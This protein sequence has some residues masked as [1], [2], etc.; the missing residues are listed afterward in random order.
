MRALED[1]Y[2]PDD[3]RPLTAFAGI[4]AAYGATV[5]GLSLLVRATGR[6]LPERM[7][8]G[9][10]A[11]TAVATYR[12]ARIVAKSPVTSPL[13]A[14]FTRFR[15]VCGE[16]ELEEEVRGTGWRKAMGE[17][18]SCPFCLGQ[19]VVTG[20]GFGWVFAP[21]ATRMVTS[22]L[23]A[24]AVADTLHYGHAALERTKG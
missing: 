1:V 23:S 24:A 6:R 3:E 5:G 16:A 13:R 19:W 22:M 4:M 17:L 7:P 18:V 9:D 20:F 21:R 14:P 12:V 8:L 2:A 11:A 15:G 10:V